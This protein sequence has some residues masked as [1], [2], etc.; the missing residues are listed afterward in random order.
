MR[1]PTHTRPLCVKICGIT[2]TEDAAAAVEAGADL[3]G[4]NFYPPSPRYL[5]PIDAAPIIR[6]LPRQVLA[7]GVFVDPAADDVRRAI[8]TAGLGLLQ[9]HGGESAVFCQGF[10]VPAMKALRVARLA[11]LADAAAGHPEGWLLVDRADPLR[12]GGSGR[13]LALEAVQPALARRLFLAGG[14]TPE[15]VAEAVRHVRPLGV[16]VCSGVE[17]APG[18]KDRARLRSFVA[19]AKTT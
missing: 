3:L 4:F 12:P 19:N 13:A 1:T 18:V 9:F 7:V 16:D 2:R 15:T 14:L 10:G 8:E 5:R 17:V 6:M 11:D